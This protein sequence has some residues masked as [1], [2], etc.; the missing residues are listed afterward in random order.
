M[1]EQPLI[2][3]GIVLLNPAEEDPLLCFFTHLFFS[4]SPNV[5]AYYIEINCCLSFIYVEKLCNNLFQCFHPLSSKIWV[6][7]FFN[8]GDKNLLK[9]QNTFKL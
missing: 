6:G 1:M 7:F 2:V 8:F 4:A 9:I 5:K 3:S